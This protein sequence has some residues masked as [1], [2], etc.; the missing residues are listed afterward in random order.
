MSGG[1]SD[2]SIKNSQGTSREGGS[3]CGKR[4]FRGTSIYA[5][6]FFVPFSFCQDK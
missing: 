5:D 3:E 1:L 2:A 4:P 6:K